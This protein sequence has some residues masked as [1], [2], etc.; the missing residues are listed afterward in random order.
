M[1]KGPK[2]AKPTPRGWVSVKGELLKSQRI[3]EAQI[4]EWEA[5]HAPKHEPAPQ[6]APQTLTEAPSVE[7]VLSEEEIHHHYGEQEEHHSEWE[8]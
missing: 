7:R 1:I 5:V 8:E 6:P 3:S 4:A 2:G